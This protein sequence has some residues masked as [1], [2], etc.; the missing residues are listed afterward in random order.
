MILRQEFLLKWSRA[1]HLSSPELL[2]CPLRRGNART[3]RKTSLRICGQM[4]RDGF[5]QLADVAKRGDRHA[6][7][8]FI[9][10]GIL[11]R[12]GKGV[13]LLMDANRNRLPLYGD[14][15]D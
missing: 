1:F 4:L 7:D 6:H 10:E 9:G 15:E 8:G 5:D 11:D 12:D 3:Q 2:L 14:T 13:R